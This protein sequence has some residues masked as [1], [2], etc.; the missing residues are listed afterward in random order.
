MDNNNIIIDQRP[1]PGGNGHP[2]NSHPFGLS[3][4]I[5]EAKACLSIE[6]RKTYE[7]LRE[8]FPL[9]PFV[10]LASMAKTPTKASDEESTSKH[11]LPR[12][13]NA[14]DHRYYFSKNTLNGG[15]FTLK[16][17]VGNNQYDDKTLGYVP[18]PSRN[19]LDR[20]G[21]KEAVNSS[22][23]STSIKNLMAEY[24]LRRLVRKDGEVIYDLASMEDPTGGHTVTH[25]GKQ[26]SWNNF[27]GIEQSLVN[28][29]GRYAADI[30]FR[31]R[32][33]IFLDWFANHGSTPTA[34]EVSS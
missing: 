21:F 30:A 34:T 16:Y 5:E 12:V 3:M 23:S 26:V 28:G 33:E 4:R 31:L 14:K 6:E 2:P 1:P 9:H 15:K 32:K 7:V 29:Q 11:A 24:D 17:L 10:I 25:D 27:Q 19:G 22:D 13:R 8:A 20:F 18:S